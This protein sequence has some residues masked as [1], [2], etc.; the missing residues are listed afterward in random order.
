[1]LHAKSQGLKTIITMTECDDAL[2]TQVESAGFS[3]SSMAA[4]AVSVC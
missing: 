1:M 2:K 3:L 4:E